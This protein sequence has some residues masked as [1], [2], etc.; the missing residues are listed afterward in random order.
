M[1]EAA[2]FSVILADDD[3]DNLKRLKIAL[4]DLGCDVRIAFDGLQAKEL[5]AKYRPDLLITEISL[6]GLDGISLTHELRKDPQYDH[7]AIVILTSRDEE[8]TEVAAFEAGATDYL[9]KPLRKQA[10]FRRIQRLKSRQRSSMG[11]EPVLIELGRVQIDKRNQR[12]QV[13]DRRIRLPKKTF[14]LLYFLA[15]NPNVAFGRDELL[16]Q[17]WARERDI[18]Q[19]TVD[20]HIRKIRE[21]TGID[22]ITTIKGVGYKLNQSLLNE[23]SAS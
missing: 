16:R 13:G 23:R 22:L 8:Y 5:C 17:I 11:Q 4:E 1:V 19:R 2:D 9:V 18:S 14:E 10:F 3:K 15:K 12:L 21:K 6:E 20:V 7:L